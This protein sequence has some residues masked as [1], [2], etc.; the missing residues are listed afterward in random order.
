MLP[1]IGIGRTHVCIVVQCPVS[2]YCTLFLKHFRETDCIESSE[3]FRC[4]LRL[5]LLRAN[6]FYLNVVLCSRFQISYAI[7]QGINCIA[8]NKLRRVLKF[9]IRAHF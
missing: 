7:G 8:K 6:V 5:L 3:R 2:R 4:E 9:L 1:R